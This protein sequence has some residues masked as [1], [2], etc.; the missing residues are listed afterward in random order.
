MSEM[1]RKCSECG[2]RVWPW[3]KSYN[4]PRFSSFQ[5]DYLFHVKCKPSVKEGESV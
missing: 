3:Q 1:D 4:H 2:K 5:P